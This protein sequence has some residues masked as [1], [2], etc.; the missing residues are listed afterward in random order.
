VAQ[1]P[2]PGICPDIHSDPALS[3]QKSPERHVAC[4]IVFITHIEALA[5]TYKRTHSGDMIVAVI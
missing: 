3:S 1:R 5:G 2:F 4:M